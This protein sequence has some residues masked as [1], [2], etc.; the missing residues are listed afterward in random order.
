MT[1]FVYPVRLLDRENVGFADRESI[2]QLASNQG[3]Q[4]ACQKHFEVTHKGWEGLISINDV[5]N[6]PNAW[7]AASENYYKALQ[8]DNKEGSQVEG[9][10]K[11]AER[12][13]EDIVAET[14]PSTADDMEAA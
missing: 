3:Y 6:H 8:G 5:G 12:M 10:G 7:F 11:A 1:I 13:E 14:G 9:G 4:L 2:M